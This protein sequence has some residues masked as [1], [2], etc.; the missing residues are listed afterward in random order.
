M[1]LKVEWSACHPEKHLFW[2]DSSSI[3]NYL[4]THS[5]NITTGT[6]I[7]LRRHVGI[8]ENCFKLNPISVILFLH[9][10]HHNR[11]H[12][13]WWQ[14]RQ[15][16]CKCQNNNL[17]SR[18]TNL[19]VVQ[20]KWTTSSINYVLKNG[21]CYS[22]EEWHTMTA[23]FITDEIG[24]KHTHNY[25]QSHRMHEC[26]HDQANKHMSPRFSC[27]YYFLCGI[28]LKEITWHYWP[29]ERERREWKS[30]TIW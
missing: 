16:E 26:G 11:T 25:I 8:A 19:S 12:S 7:S 27:L 23:Q 14:W 6:D 21:C 5:L 24:E 18:I 10:I 2:E 30:G 13:K 22:S 3:M 20:N 28:N 29:W 1:V 15:Q 9:R 4:Y 17:L